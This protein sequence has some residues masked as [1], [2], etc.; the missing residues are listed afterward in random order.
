M[1]LERLKLIRDCLWRVRRCNIVS[2]YI[3]CSILKYLWYKNI[4][5]DLKL[6]I[7][8]AKKYFGSKKVF[9]V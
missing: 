4:C 2:G 5:M 8:C 6:Y 1:G 3:Y 7:Y 9:V